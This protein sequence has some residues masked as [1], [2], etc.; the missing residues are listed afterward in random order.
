MRFK[1]IKDT[2][3]L[4]ESLS[5]E[6]MINHLWDLGYHYNF[7]RFSDKQI[8]C[9]YYQYKDTPWTP[10][11]RKKK[12]NSTKIKSS[13]TKKNEKSKEIIEEPSYEEE[14]KWKDWK[15]YGTIEG[16][17]ILWKDGYLAIE[18]LNRYFTSEDE[19]REY[20]EEG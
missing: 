17:K 1:L 16:N 7:N 11:K 10:P 9:M 6:Y 20:L 18:G 12:N 8:A 4:E 14:I 5:T 2:S 3:P 13:K 19:I 15:P